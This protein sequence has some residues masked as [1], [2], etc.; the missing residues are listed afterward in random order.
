MYCISDDWIYHLTCLLLSSF[1]LISA[2]CCLLFCLLLF[3]IYTAAPSARVK[4]ILTT[5]H[6]MCS[7]RSLSNGSIPYLFIFFANVYQI[8]TTEIKSNIYMERS[9]RTMDKTTDISVINL[10][11]EITLICG[12]REIFGLDCVRECQIWRI[13]NKI[14]EKTTISCNTICFKLIKHEMAR[15]NKCTSKSY[16]GISRV[17]V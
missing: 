2:I 8:N 4:Q 13:H 7:S 15:E 14:N 11:P 10:T 16:N 3:A 1:S 9:G 6:K 17:S 5:N 12:T